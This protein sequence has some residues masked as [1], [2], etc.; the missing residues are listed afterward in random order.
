MRLSNYH[1]IT[2]DLLFTIREKSIKFTQRDVH[3]WADFIRPAVTAV[4]GTSDK[5]SGAGLILK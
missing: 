4:I 5:C 2:V 1:N 3:R